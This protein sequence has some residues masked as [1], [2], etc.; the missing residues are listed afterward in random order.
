M[1]RGQSTTQRAITRRVAMALTLVLVC[2]PT[3]VAHAAS[4]INQSLFG[5]VAIEGADPVAYFL[6]GRAVAGSSDFTHD[7]DGAEWH[8]ASAA[9]RDAFAADPDRYAPRYGG[10]C[11]W[12]VSKGSTAGI[13]PEAWTIVDGALYLNYSKSVQAT[14]AKDIPGNIAKADTN[15]PGVLN[16]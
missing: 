13:D 8:F 7:W 10:Y 12:A 3:A 6:E 16:N 5:G 9:N 14:W 1:M 2:G 15:W 11:A 4:T